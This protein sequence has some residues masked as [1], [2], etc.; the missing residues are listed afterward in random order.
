MKKKIYS[1]MFA[2][3]FV[4]AALCLSSCED[5][6]NSC[7]AQGYLDCGDGSCCGKGYPYSGGNA[8]WQTMSGCRSS[9]YAC[10]KCW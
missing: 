9:G 5:T 2:G 7:H 1:F 3:L 4:L 8:C 10:N 6:D